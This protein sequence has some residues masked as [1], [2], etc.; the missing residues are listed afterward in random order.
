MKNRHKKL[1]FA[2]GVVLVFKRNCALQILK[3][4]NFDGRECLIITILLCV[5]ARVIQAL[6]CANI[7]Q[8]LK[9]Y[10]VITSFVF[11]VLVLK[12]VLV[13]LLPVVVFCVMCNV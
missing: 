3:N 7:I 13:T 9:R 11:N 6:F 10:D 5:P 2:G 1:I 8:K 12:L 4:D